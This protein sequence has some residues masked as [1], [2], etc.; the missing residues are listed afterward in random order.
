MTDYY[1]DPTNG[2]N[3]NRGTS[4]D[5]A[6]AD[7]RPF[8]SDV[9]LTAG[10]TV[11]LSGGVY[12]YDSALD[13]SG[14]TGAA[15]APVVIEAATGESPVFDFS[16]SSGQGVV[17]DNSQY[18]SLRGVEV[19]HADVNN[20]RIFG[21]ESGGSG[22]QNAVDVVVENCEIHGHGV[23]GSHGNGVIVAYGAD[24][25]VVRGCELYDG[26]SGGNSDGFHAAVDARNT[27]LEDCWIHHNSDD[28]IDTFGGHTHDPDNPATFR[29][30]V[31]YR[32][33]TDLSGSV[34]GNGVGFKFGDCNRRAGG[35]RLEHCVAFENRD[36]GIGNPCIDEGLTLYNC[37][38]VNN[39]KQN[40][41]LS[42]ESADHEIANCIAQGGDGWDLKLEGAKSVK[43]C[44]WDESSRGDFN[45]ATELSFQSTDPSSGD[46]L[47]H[48]VGSPAIDAGIDVGLSYEG[49]APDWGAYESDGASGD[50]DTS[51]VVRV[52]DGSGWR[53]PTVKYYD[54]S[55]FIPL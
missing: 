16:A 19:R 26:K 33:G 34:T 32:N 29:R 47:R 1:T 18:T 37:S 46:F 5:T 23:G 31:C 17:L 49:S 14:I 48:P 24:G 40:I 28:G 20:V 51:P 9:T 8:E 11:T 41:Y 39:G 25:V 42:E 44:N 15:E 52:Y 38:A 55:G 10:D 6:F 4:P 22:S 35:H 50:G 2:S 7:L 3:T 36:R 30:V 43:A 54:G 21:N 45:S 13:L 53:Q 12:D 27:L